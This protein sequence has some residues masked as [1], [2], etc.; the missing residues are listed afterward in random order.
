MKTFLV[1][2]AGGVQ[3][4]LDHFHDEIQ[5]VV[6][7]FR[8][9][10]EHSTAVVIIFRNAEYLQSA[11]DAAGLCIDLVEQFA[12][13]VVFGVHIAENGFLI[14]PCTGSDRSA[15]FSYQT[16]SLSNRCRS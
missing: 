4:F 3:D 13:G 16:T 1:I 5:F 12:V 7:E 9:D 8:A 11:V 14:R 10:A 15:H 2:Q 6:Q